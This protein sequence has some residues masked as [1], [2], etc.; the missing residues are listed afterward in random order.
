MG[1]RRVP[2][3]RAASPR[4]LQGSVIVDELDL[5]GLTVHQAELRLESF[6]VRVAASE[7]VL[8]QNSAERESV[9][10]L[11]FGPL[12]PRHSRSTWRVL[13]PV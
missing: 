12:A 13:E 1:K 3:V 6:L 9:R 5:H 10:L 7:P 11:K 8:F 2:Q 4:T